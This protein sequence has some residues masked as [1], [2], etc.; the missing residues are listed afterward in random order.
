VIDHGYRAS[1]LRYLLLSV[2]YR[3]QLTFSFDILAQAD[4][5]LTR[6]M[7]FLARVARVTGGDAHV[8]V[9]KRV[10]LARSEFRDRISA[11][12]NVPGALGVMFE[13][14]RE[15]N[16]AMDQEAGKAVGA[17]DA[18]LIREAFDEFDR[19]LGVMALRRRE[20][21]T[22]P[23]PE[24]E[25]L[26]LIEERR[27]ARRDR[28]FARADEIRKDLDARGVVLEDSSAGTRWKRK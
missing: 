14:L 16:A 7:D 27:E 10:T 22:P 3:K 26:A 19:V 24:A 4:A 6:I 9:A 21:E 11:D 1:A 23:V 13:L 20:E 2:H 18:A 17:P 8:S 5:A 12:L 15:M 28:Q 25:I